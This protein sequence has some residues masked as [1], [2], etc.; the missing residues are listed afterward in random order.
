MP[1]KPATSAPTLGQSYRH[2][3]PQHRS[4]PIAPTR[5]PAPPKHLTTTAQHNYG[6]R[7]NLRR[8]TY[9]AI[10][11][12]TAVACSQEEIVPGVTDSTF[13]HAMVELR[14]LPLGGGLD[15]TARRIT[16][17][18]ILQRYGL[19]SAKLESAAK[20]LADDPDRAAAIWQAIERA[21]TIPPP[22]PNTG[23][24]PPASQPPQ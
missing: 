6:A 23:T 8:W 24:Q 12:A 1:R 21:A 7:M 19:D 3:P 10:V 14:R 18:A 22:A 16:R 5:G 9:L 2:A 15:P 20:A 17:D 11:A 4:Y 13:V